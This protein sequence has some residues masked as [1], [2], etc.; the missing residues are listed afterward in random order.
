LEAKSTKGKSLPFSNIKQSQINGFKAVDGQY[1]GVMGVFA[2]EF[3]EIKQ[4]YF[5]TAADVIEYM[6]STTT[7]KSLPLDFFKTKGERARI[8]KGKKVKLEIEETIKKIKKR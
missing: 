2:V 5:I 8:Q 1:E 7:R 4:T 3:S 6:E